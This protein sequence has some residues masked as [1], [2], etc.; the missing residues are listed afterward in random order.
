M[1]ICRRR[2][3]HLGGAA[4]IPFA[5]QLMRAEHSAAQ[6]LPAS[7]DRPLAERL[8]AYASGLRYEDLDKPTIER[9]KAL[10]IDTIGCGMGAWEDR[11]I[12]N[13]RPIALSV[14]GPATH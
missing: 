3:L 1:K 10:L 2:L 6:S 14:G 7:S 4:A 12:R 11:P 8:A 13:R 9:V 5:S